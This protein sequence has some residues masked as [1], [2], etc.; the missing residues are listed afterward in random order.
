MTEKDQTARA[1]AMQAGAVRYVSGEAC[2]AG[3]NGERYVLSG[4]CVECSRAAV[5][6]NKA[7]VR[8]ARLAIATAAK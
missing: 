2:P 3:H 7:K 5:R 6:A 4:Y 8:A 1:A